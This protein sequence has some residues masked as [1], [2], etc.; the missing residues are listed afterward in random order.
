MLKEFKCIIFE[1]I[2]NC[3]KESVK[4]HNDFDQNTSIFYK[5]CLL[6]IYM[7]MPLCL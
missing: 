1:E 2:K 5:N 6:H 7:K 4:L 3:I